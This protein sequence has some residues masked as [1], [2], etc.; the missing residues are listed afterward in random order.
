MLAP[1]TIPLMH[2]QASSSPEIAKRKPD[3][4]LYIALL[5]QTMQGM[6]LAMGTHRSP[7]G[8][9]YACSTAEVTWANHRRGIC[10]MK[11][12]WSLVILSLIL[13]DH[14]VVRAESRADSRRR[15]ANHR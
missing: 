2:W 3:F 8:D 11:S 15:V 1:S 7:S 13:F 10:V 5:I 12:R 14:G 6:A 4:D 9:V